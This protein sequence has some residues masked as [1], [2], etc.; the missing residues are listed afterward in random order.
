MSLSQQQQ[1]NDLQAQLDALKRIHENPTLAEQDGS[2]FIPVSKNINGD[3]VDYKIVNP[4]TTF[5]Q[6]VEVTT[7]FSV[8]N[9]YNRKLVKVGVNG[10]NPVNITIY[11][12]SNVV[13]LGSRKGLR[14]E[15]LQATSTTPTLT[16]NTGVNLLYD[17]DTQPNFNGVNSGLRLTYLG[18]NNW[19]VNK[20]SN[21]ATSPLEEAIQGTLIEANI[22]APLGTANYT[23][24]LNAGVLWLLVLNG[25][26]TFN[27]S[28]LPPISNTI[29]RTALITGGAINL[30]I[31]L[32]ADPDNDNYDS[33][34]LNRFEFE[35]TTLASSNSL[36]RYSLKNLEDA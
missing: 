23:M 21:Q 5:L 17:G 27:F 12:E 25:T 19:W 1:I 36:M 2:E 14:V 32:I 10:V 33:S 11:A 8:S 26:T 30:P 31:G 24:D 20:I 18:D 34:K 6:V 29:R 4:I 28:N 3:W 13:S 35:I 22:P 16:V 7:D 9:A 15:L